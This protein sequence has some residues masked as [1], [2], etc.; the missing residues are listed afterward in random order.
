VLGVRVGFRASSLRGLL[1]NG[2]LAASH[3]ARDV[4]CIVGLLGNALELV[5]SLA[6]GGRSVLAVGKAVTASTGLAEHALDESALG[7]AGAE[8]NSVDDKED[9]RATLEDDGRSEDAEPEG[10]LKRCDKRHAG[11]IVVLDETSN[12]LRNAGGGGLLAG[13]HD[14]RR[15]D[16]G[17]QD[18]AS[19]G[20]DVE[21]AVDG[22]GQE[23]QRHLAGEKPDESHGWG[24]S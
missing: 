3:V 22:E 12:G 17:E 11:I 1:L 8:E 4:S 14:R 23:S 19:V 7:D 13:G 20:G 16:G 18:A 21:D 6:G 15:L 9:P 5:P 2:G 24:K 10:Q